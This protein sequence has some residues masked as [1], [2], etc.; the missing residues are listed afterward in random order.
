MTL[1]EMLVA[2]AIFAVPPDIVIFRSMEDE[3]GVM[4]VRSSEHEFRPL[5][6]NTNAAEYINASMVGIGRTYNDEAPCLLL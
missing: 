6:W 2:G 3:V 1:D 5:R 4:P